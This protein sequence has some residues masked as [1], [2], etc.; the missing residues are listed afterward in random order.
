MIGDRANDISA[1]KACGIHSVAV[2]W[3]YGK[4]AELSDANSDFIIDS[5][6]ELISLLE[7][8]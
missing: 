2:T 7:T 5:P 3:G 8:V 4:L 6:H 1:A